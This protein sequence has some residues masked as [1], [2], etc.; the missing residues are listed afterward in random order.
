MKDYN[1]C[2]A[3]FIASINELQEMGTFM[4]EA[5]VKDHASYW[6]YVNV[7]SE[8]DADTVRMLSTVRSSFVRD[9]S[10]IS[11]GCYMLYCDLVRAWERA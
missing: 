5:K 11:I 3:R 2:I 7:L 8:S 9:M 1:A 4:S 6:A 10:N